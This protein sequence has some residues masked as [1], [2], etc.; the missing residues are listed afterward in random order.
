MITGN[1]Q[2]KYDMRNHGQVEFK[3]FEISARIVAAT[4]PYVSVSS[5]SDLICSEMSIGRSIAVG[6]KKVRDM[7]CLEKV[8]T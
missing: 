3:V 8:V 1:L 2:S 4:K 7:G 5:Y 6:I